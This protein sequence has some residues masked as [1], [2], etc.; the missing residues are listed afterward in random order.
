MVALKGRKFFLKVASSHSDDQ[1]LLDLLIETDP[2]GD[3]LS[4]KV[5]RRKLCL[6]FV[7]LAGQPEYKYPLGYI[8][9]V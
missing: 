8:G 4:N 2:T 5:G 1:Q 6:N 3:L 7:P 9:E